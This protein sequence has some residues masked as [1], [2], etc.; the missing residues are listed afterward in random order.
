MG[1]GGDLGML[2]G[3]SGVQKELKLDDKQV[4]KAKEFADKTREQMREHFQ[5]L[6]GL[7]DAERTH[8]AARD[9]ARR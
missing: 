6:Q 5:E 9:H 7:E 3:N 1:M 2:I 4:E 8:Q